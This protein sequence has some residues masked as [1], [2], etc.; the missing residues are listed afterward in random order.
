MSVSSTH[1]E[2][3]W[4]GCVCQPIRFKLQCRI[5][6][7]LYPAGTKIGLRF[8]EYLYIYLFSIWPQDMRGQRRGTLWTAERNYG[9]FVFAGT[10][11]N[12]VMVSRNHVFHQLS[13]LLCKAFTSRLRCSSKPSCW[14]FNHHVYSASSEMS[15]HEADQPDVCRAVW[16]AVTLE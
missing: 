15:V 1:T 9:L 5:T 8:H 11:A 13:A 12:A 16:K 3:V 4:E 14:L 6:A 7:L 2:K 10:K